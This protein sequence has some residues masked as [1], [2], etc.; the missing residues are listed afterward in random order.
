MWEWGHADPGVTFFTFF[1]V[2][3]GGVQAGLFVWQLI[4]IR[5][6]LADAKLAAEASKEAANAATRQAKIAEESFAKLERPY[7]Y[8]IDATPF[9]LDRKSSI[10]N[11]VFYVTYTVVNYGKTPAI[12]KHAQGICHG[13]D[14]RNATGPDLPLAFNYDHVLVSSPVLRPDEIRQGIREDV[15]QNSVEFTADDSVFDDSIYEYFPVHDANR[16]VFLWRWDHGT[17]RFIKHGENNWEK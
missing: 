5:R 8:I 12:V 15:A 17:R 9:I 11:P 1:L 13:I 7:L 14:Y 6:S 4:L 2:I 10:G 3:V 16:D